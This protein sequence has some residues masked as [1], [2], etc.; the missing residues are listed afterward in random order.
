MDVQCYKCKTVAKVDLDQVPLGKS[1]VSCPRCHARIDFFKK[2]V[3]GSNLSNL[4]EVRFMAEGDDLSEQ[5][6]EAGEEWRVVDVVEPCPEKGKGKK[7]EVENMGRCPNQR[8]V[9]RLSGKKSFYRTCLY[10]NGRKIFEKSS[11]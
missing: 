11:N 9:L 4:A 8:L 2:V 5:F 7:C 6:C 1:Y 3:P 10:R